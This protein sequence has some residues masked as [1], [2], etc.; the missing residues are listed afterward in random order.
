MVMKRS[1]EEPQ[2]YRSDQATWWWNA[3]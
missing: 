1:D 3:V 2:W